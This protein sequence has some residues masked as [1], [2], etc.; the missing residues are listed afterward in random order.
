MVESLLQDATTNRTIC[1]YN[2]LDQSIPFGVSQWEFVVPHYLAPTHTLS[3]GAGTPPRT[4]PATT[5][6]L[7]EV[8]VCR[9]STALGLVPTQR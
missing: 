3:A 1:G 8:S 7:A 4:R 5:I 9:T 2:S 6:G